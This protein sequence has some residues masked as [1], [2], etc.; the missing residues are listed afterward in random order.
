MTQALQWAVLMGSLAVVSTSALVALLA[1]RGWRQ[2]QARNRRALRIFVE[3]EV[4]RQVGPISA[5]LANHDLEI[6]LLT[7]FQAEDRRQARP[8]LSIART[9]GEPDLDAA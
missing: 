9:G 8:N 2:F 3:R 4:V 6:E 7:A 5:K 1:V